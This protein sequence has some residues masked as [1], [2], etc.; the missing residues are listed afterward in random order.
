M[1]APLVFG[2]PL[3][4]G[5]GGGDGGGAGGALI[6][7][8]PPVAVCPPVVTLTGPVF[9]YVEA[10][11]TVAVIAVAVQLEVAALI[12][13]KLTAPELPRLAPLMTTWVPGT[14]LE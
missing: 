2:Y 5:A 6:V 1:A 12:P 13:L 7:K 11:G 4:E 14:A 9:G 10:V 8:L 3:I